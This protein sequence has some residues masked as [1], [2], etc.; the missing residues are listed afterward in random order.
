MRTTVTL[1]DEIVEDLRE[2][3]GIKET[4]ALVRR[5]LLEMRQRE[6]A[7]ALIALGGSDPNA[8]LAPRRRFF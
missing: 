5:A 7:R 1:D 4:S 6:A 3:T 2:S 8:K